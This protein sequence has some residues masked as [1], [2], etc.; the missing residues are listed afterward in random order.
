MMEKQYKQTDR[1]RV[2][3]NIAAM[4]ACELASIQ[5]LPAVQEYIAR[6]NPLVVADWSGPETYERGELVV[7][8]TS[9]GRQENPWVIAEVAERGSKYDPQGVLLRALG[10]DLTCWY[11]NESFIRIKG[12][13]GSLLWE[14]EQKKFEAKVHKAHRNFDEMWHCF[15]GLEF[16]RD[17]PALA[18]LFIGERYGGLSKRTKPYVIT[19]KWNKRTTIKSIMAQ[20]TEQGY[21]TR[22]FE[23]MDESYDGP[24][25]G[26]T[27]LTKET[28][29]REGVWGW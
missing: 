11:G 14:G 16:D 2:L 29:R 19:L 28:A 5:S 6:R 12:L 15:R 27:I 4:L 23:P 25:E 1:E 13:S 9:A 17:D 26:V 22:E 10:T 20:M 21:G 7:C 8:H 3:M 18:R 24:M